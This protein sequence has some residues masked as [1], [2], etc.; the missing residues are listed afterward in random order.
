MAGL[1]NPN[2]Y[3]KQEAWQSFIQNFKETPLREEHKT[4][5]SGLS[6]INTLFG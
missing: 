4:I 2:Y 6:E 1:N 5:F 3:S